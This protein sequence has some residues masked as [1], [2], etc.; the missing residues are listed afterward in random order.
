MFYTVAYVNPNPLS[1]DE[2]IAYSTSRDGRS[3]SPNHGTARTKIKL[4]D[5]QKIAN[6]KITGIA[7]PCLVRHGSEWRLWFDAD[8]DKKR[9]PQS[10]LAVA[11]GSTPDHFEMVHR[12][13]PLPNGFASFWEPDVARRPDGTGSSLIDRVAEERL[14]V[15]SL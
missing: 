10:F 7:R 14:G 3:W 13:P 9:A 11:H 5:P 8:M 1:F 2:W 4:V 15:S 6:G 12:Y